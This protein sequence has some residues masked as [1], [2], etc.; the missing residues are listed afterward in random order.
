METKTPFFKELSDGA[1]REHYR[2]LRMLAY[3]NAAMAASGAV[4]T[5][6]CASQMGRLMR[7]IG[8]IEGI[9]RQ[10]RIS[11]VVAGPQE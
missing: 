3:N 1:L 2:S 7:H 10:R 11:L 9:A 6:K 8:I 4:N 5:R